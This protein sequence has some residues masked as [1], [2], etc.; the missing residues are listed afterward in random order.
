MKTV[1]VEDDDKVKQVSASSP[2]SQNMVETLDDKG[3]KGPL[4]HNFTSEGSQEPVDYVQRQ[5]AKTTRQYH[6]VKY[7]I[8]KCRTNTYK[9]SFW[10]RTIS[11]WNNLPHQT[12]NIKD[13]AGFRASIGNNI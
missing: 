5:I 2:G 6:P 7:R 13:K 12:L 1:L 3:E 8:M 4:G 10:P 11:E 9:Y